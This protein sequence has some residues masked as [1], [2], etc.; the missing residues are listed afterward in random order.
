[1]ALIVV[2]LKQTKKQLETKEAEI[3]QAEHA[4]YDAGMTKAAESLTAQLREVA[5]AFCLEV[6]DQALNAARV[7]TESEL[8]APDKCWGLCPKIQFIG[9]T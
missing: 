9:M 6:Q 3:S 2:E 7:C 1:M 8:R 5:R 4:A